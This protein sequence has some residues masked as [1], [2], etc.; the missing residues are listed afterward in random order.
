MSMMMSICLNVT[1]KKQTKQIESEREREKDDISISV[2]V[3]PKKICVIGFLF[4]QIYIPDNN[5]KKILKLST[6]ISTK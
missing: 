1:K 3:I 4:L 6:T 2:F 5:K